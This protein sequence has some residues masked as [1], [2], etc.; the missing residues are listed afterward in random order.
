MK[1]Y[2]VIVDKPKLIEFIRWLPDLKEDEVYYLCLFGRSKYI[3]DRSLHHV[4]SDKAQLK[5]FVSN[6]ERL[7]Q[8]IMQLECPLESYIQRTT[9]IPQEA[10]ALYITINPRSLTD[11]TFSSMEKFLKLIKHPYNGYNPEAEVMSEIQ[12]SRSRKIFKDFDF[13][14]ELT[15]EEIKQE[16]LEKD[17]LNLSA[18]K[19]LKTRGG[20][21]LLVELKKC[22]KKYEK[23]WNQKLCDLQEKYSSDK[24]NNGDIMIPVPGTYQGGFCPYFI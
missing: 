18:L 15:P 19:F 3:E 9:V 23:S 1:N 5:R 4:R 11:A 21:H 8:K 14:G 2:V 10:L 17:I 20:F 6:K 7:L 16:I 13:D 12:K 24:E 22:E